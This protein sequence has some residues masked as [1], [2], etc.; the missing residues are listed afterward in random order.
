MKVKAATVLVLAAI[1]INGA[2]ITTASGNEQT[3]EYVGSNTGPGVAYCGLSGEPVAS[4][5]FDVKST[6]GVLITIDDLVSG[7]NVWI[8]ARVVTDNESNPIIGRGCGEISAVDLPADAHSI[9]VW[10]YGAPETTNPG[11]TPGAGGV[12][13]TVTATFT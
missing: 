8:V 3:Q 12:M 1:L 7:N 11:C 6:A 10:V 5:C 2:G 9:Y 4:A 13:G